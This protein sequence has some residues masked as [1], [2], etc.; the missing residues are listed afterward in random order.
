M[1]Y[2]LK[3]D[4]LTVAISDRGAELQSICGAD[5]TEYLWQGDRT[6]WEDRAPVLFP[7]CG[8]FWEGKCTDAGVPYDPGMHGF[9][10]TLTTDVTEKSE[11]T[12][13][14]C[15]RDSAETRR[16]Y[17]Y[18]FELRLTYCLRGRELTLTAE[19]VNRDGRTLP[20]AL[21]LHPGFNLPFAGGTMEDYTVRFAGAGGAV[22]RV[23]FDAEECFPIGG[24]RDFPLRDG[25]Y[26]DPTDAF[27]AAGSGFFC[28][29]PH[30]VALEK[31]GSGESVTLRFSED[32]RY[33]G[34]WKA[35]GGRFLCMEPWTSM[36]AT[37]GENTE[38]TE[39]PDLLRIAAGE[40]RT[41]SCTF[42][43]N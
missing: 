23:N 11:E 20:F 3:N 36:P 31:R 25:E 40:T 5:G 37:H 8:R 27:F 41:L 4:F 21:G 16:K 24:S 17:P 30:T 43:F 26:F 39:K 7:F 2:R 1:I 22:R 13:T 10:R 6:Y 12:I 38:L 34:L 29:M 42:G 9:F 28:G 19:I 33:F 18:A 35:V 32:F 14:F 15:A